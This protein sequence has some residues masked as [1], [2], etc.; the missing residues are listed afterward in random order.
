MTLVYAAQ[1][2]V[3]VQRDWLALS[4]E[5]AAAI[6]TLAAAA[7]AV[8]I[9]R[10][11]PKLAALGYTAAHEQHVVQEWA[12][13]IRQALSWLN[14]MPSLTV[15]ARP[16]LINGIWEWLE[17]GWGRGRPAEEAAKARVQT[18]L[19]TLE[20]LLGHAMSSQDVSLA[21]P[22]SLAA[23]NL[24]VLATQLELH[25]AGHAMPALPPDPTP[26][27]F[28]EPSATGPVGDEL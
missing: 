6:G 10:Q 15:F 12:T 9:V 5:L 1:T 14:K 28:Q 27:I 11:A 19:K 7:A 3:V 25:L 2:L 16:L 23:K 26:P 18:A 8:Y 4:V 22:I 17:S 21:V 13:A 20:G 24:L